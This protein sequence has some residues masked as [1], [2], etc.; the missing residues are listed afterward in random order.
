METFLFYVCGSLMVLAGLMMVASR[1]AVVSACWLVFG[2]LNAAGIFAALSALFL[3]VLQVLVYAGAIMVLFLFVV[4]MLQ[5][6][7][8]AEERR[9]VRPWLWPFI[10]MPV[11]A[12]VFAVAGFLRRSGPVPFER[13]LPEN[14]GA[15]TAV[16]ALLLNHYLLAF[17]LISILLLV[18]I[19]GALSIG[20]VERRL[21]WR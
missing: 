7:I 20:K 12:I 17:E 18:G 16:A 8:L 5:G 11:L 1:N 3:A 9:P 15:P 13:P 4:M 6:P 10:G 21:P 19:V 14:F 2:F